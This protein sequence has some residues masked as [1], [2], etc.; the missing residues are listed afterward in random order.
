LTQFMINISDFIMNHY[1]LLIAMTIWFA[2]A[3]IAFKNTHQWKLTLGK[4]ALNMPVFWYIVRQWNVILFINSFSLLLDSWVLVL[5]A[6][7][8]TANV[9]WNIYYKKDIVRVKNEMETWIKLSNAMGLNISNREIIFSN[10]YF[11]EDLVHM[12]SIWEE[13]WSIGKSIEKVWINYSKDLKRYISNLMTMLEPFIIVFV[14]AL[15]GTI[16]IAIMLPFF[17]LVKVAKKM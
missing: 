3:F 6:L 10:P 8:T 7:E 5:E 4:I 2:I 14:W 13:T 1:I 9:V 16:I 15:V 17:N 12:I 11:P